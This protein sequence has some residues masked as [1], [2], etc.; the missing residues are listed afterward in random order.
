MTKKYFNWKIN[1]Q[2]WG[3]FSP[4]SHEGKKSHA[5]LLLKLVNTQFLSYLREMGKILQDGYSFKIFAEVVRFFFL[6]K[7]SSMLLYSTAQSKKSTLTTGISKTNLQIEKSYGDFLFPKE[8]RLTK[9]WKSLICKWVVKG[10]RIWQHLTVLAIQPPL[11]GSMIL[12][13]IKQKKNN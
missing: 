11:P 12:K 5:T 6:I 1:W 13:S 10:R 4:I 2:I 8:F 3:H 7:V 9:S